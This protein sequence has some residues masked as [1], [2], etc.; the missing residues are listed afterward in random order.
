MYYYTYCITHLE[1]NCYYLG[2]RTSKSAP[3]F[4]QTYLGS[5]ILIKRSVK[6]HKPIAFK[7][8]IIQLYPSLEE[9]NGAEKLLITLETLNDPLCLNLALGGHGGNMGPKWKARLLEVIQSTEYRKH[10]SEV[11]SQPLI[12][13]RISESIKSTMANPEWKIKFSAIQKSTQNKPEE[14]LRNSKAQKIAQNLPEVK[15]Q[16]RL[17]MLEK[18]QDPIIRDKHLH[19]CN[20]DRFREAQR[21]K[22]LGSLWINKDGA[23][24]YVKRELLDTLLDEGWA[25]G[26]G[27]RKKTGHVND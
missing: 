7:K 20:T 3:I 18:F 5:G 16:K 1:T 6:K 27:S 4:D 14:R 13:L 22:L 17:T 21:N 2:K 11:I 10:M 23:K 9:L 8:E 25:L 15:N 26:M 12:R 24:K 19:A